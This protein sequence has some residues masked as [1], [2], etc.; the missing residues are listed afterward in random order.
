MAASKST[1]VSS[2]TGTF[3]RIVLL[4]LCLV[5]L[6]AGASRGA[7]AGCCGLGCCDCSCVAAVPPDTEEE[8]LAAIRSALAERG[9]V[10]ESAELLVRGEADPAAAVI[11]TPDVRDGAAAAQ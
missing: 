4:V 3:G 1:P 5:P 8:L 2:M 9:Y 6:V 11:R 7:Q 10:L